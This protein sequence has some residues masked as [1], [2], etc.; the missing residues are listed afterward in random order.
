MFCSS[1]GAA[2]ESNAAF[3]P[4]CGSKIAAVQ[5]APEFGAAPAVAQKSRKNLLIGIG[6]G[7]ALLLILAF[8][9]PSL[10][11]GIGG[12]DFRA[13]LA[14][15]ELDETS[16]GVTLDDDGRGLF[17][18]AEGDEDYSGMSYSDQQCVLDGLKVPSSVMTQIN[19]TS[20]LMGVQDAE[21]DDIA[22][23]WTY[24]P[25]NGLEMSIKKK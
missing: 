6:G 16:S 14:D 12:T 25:D 21:W 17:L 5:A 15:C 3:C 8:V 22:A 4:S 10:L 13:V 11:G 19:N 23:S 2:M 7:A 1:C 20:S 9:V 24:H 18:D